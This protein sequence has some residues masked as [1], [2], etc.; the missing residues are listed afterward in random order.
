[1]LGPVARFCL[2][3][4]TGIQEF[5]EAAKHSF[6]AQAAAEIEKSGDKAN[7][8]RI[9]IITGIHRRDVMRIYDQGEA[10]E[11]SGFAFFA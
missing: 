8:S 10:R 3:H 4:G 1:M 2:K 11:S 6:V 9:S 7:V 5:L